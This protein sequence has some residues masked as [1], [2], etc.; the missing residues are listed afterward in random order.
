MI[1]QVFAVRDKAVDAFMPPFY[2]RSKGEAIRS[3]S[4]AVGDGK[5][6]FHNNRGDYELYQIGE[7]DDNSGV[8]TSEC[9][10]VI[11]ALEVAIDHALQ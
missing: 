6:Q 11:S 2:A 9:S 1:L 10:R 4:A 7:F 8:L 3:F 5:H